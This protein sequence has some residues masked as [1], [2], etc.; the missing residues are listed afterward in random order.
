METLASLRAGELFSQ[1]KGRD[2]TFFAFFC[3]KVRN[4]G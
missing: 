2:S 3:K 1:K 4:R